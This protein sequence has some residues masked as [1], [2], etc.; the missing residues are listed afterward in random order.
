[1]KRLR[2]CLVFALVVFLGFV[3]SGCAS[4][5]S[6]GG[7]R[8]DIRSDPSEAVIKIT[9]TSGRVVFD[10]HTPASP[11]LNRGDGYFKGATYKI[12]VSKEG[13]KTQEIPLASQLNGGWYILGNLIF[14]G[15][16]GWLIVD[17]LTGGMWSLSPDKVS[18]Q[19]SKEASF[20]EQKDGLMIVLLSDIPAD[21]VPQLKPV[22]AQD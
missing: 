20:L 15:L 9:D 16:I 4:I 17:P 18:A 1:M 3:I 2:N 14:G 10:S 11:T 21:V 7:Q 19:M 6:S 5:I 8:I 22:P 12:T 13:Y